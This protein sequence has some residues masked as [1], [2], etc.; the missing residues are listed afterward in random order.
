MNLNDLIERKIPPVPWVE[1]EKI[2]WHE[3]EFSKRMLKE[4][5]SQAHDAASRREVLI[6]QHVDWIHTHI[7][8][9]EPTKVL[10][11]GC[12]PGLYTSRLAKLG[13]ECVGIDYAPASIAYARHQAE[14]QGLSCRYIEAD[15]REAS[16][17]S[18]YGLVIMVHGELNVF[19]PQEIKA[20]LGRSLRA[21]RAGGHFIAEV[22]TLAAVREIGERGSHWYSS[23]SGLFSD[24]PHLG[25]KEAF[26]DGDE[27]VSTERYYILD[28]ESGNVERYAASIQAYREDEY[29]ELFESIGYK[30]VI[31]YPSLT[32]KVPED[33]S[34]YIVIAA[35]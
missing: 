19:R 4:H 20:I 11:L 6:D 12:G 35:E 14:E 28:I 1:G 25:L 17:G 7:L 34:P 9:G 15:V 27:R 18:D 33:D 26:W 10:D 30:G 8:E 23:S 16:F 32:G 13:H 31:I 21:L 2:P 29:L 22:H 24:R 3:P 5:L